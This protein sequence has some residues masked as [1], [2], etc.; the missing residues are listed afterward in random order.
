MPY[1]AAEIASA[2][3]RTGNKW[4]L[5]G[6]RRRWRPGVGSARALRVDGRLFVLMQ[7]PHYPGTSLATHEPCGPALDR[8][9][10]VGRE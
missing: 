6:G 3:A 8:A 5:K 7:E 10:Q 9:G 1:V 4:P 2:V